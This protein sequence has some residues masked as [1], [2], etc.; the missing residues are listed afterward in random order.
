MSDIK[1]YYYISKYSISY[2][3][4]I[5]V[6]I[7]L[8]FGVFQKYCNGQTIGKKLMKIKVVDNNTNENPNIWKHLLRTI[9]MYYIY[10]GGLIPLIINTIL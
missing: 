4:V 5:I 7:L 6:G 10:I 1:A 2:N 8:Y 9:P 3:I